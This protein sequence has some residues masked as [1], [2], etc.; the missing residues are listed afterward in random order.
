MRK[1]GS[2]DGHKGHKEGSQYNF[3]ILLEV[4]VYQTFDVIPQMGLSEIDQ[5]SQLEPA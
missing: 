2:H 3:F 5:Q 4:A 1:K